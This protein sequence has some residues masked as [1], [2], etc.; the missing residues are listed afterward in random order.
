MIF[1]L[2]FQ[3]DYTHTHSHIHC[4]SYYFIYTRHIRQGFAIHSI[5]KRWMVAFS[6]FVKIR[7]ILRNF[8]S[9][10]SARLTQIPITW[11]MN[12]Y[13]FKYNWKCEFAPFQWKAQNFSSKFRTKCVLV[14]WFFW[15]IIHTPMMMISHKT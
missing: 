12:L 14:R 13:L 5:L 6:V 9:G 1:T 2:Y 7:Q 4:C 3:I 8:K 11:N 15:V 10:F